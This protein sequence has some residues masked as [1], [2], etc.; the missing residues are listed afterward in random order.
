MVVGCYSRQA[1]SQTELEE[2][3]RPGQ[4]HEAAERL[5]HVDHPY[6]PGCLDLRVPERGEV[7]AGEVD[8]AAPAWVVA[9][10]EASHAPAL[11]RPVDC[12]ESQDFNRVER[13]QPT[14]TATPTTAG[15]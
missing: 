8:Q 1:S 3:R 15:M 6:R 5:H 13:E 9:A 14:S 4:H 7:D 2:R 12:G 11:Q 10:V